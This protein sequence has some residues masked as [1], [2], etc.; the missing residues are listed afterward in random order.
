MIRKGRF[1]MWNGKEYALV[2]YQRQYYLQTE[3]VCEERNG[4]ERMSGKEHVLIRSVSLKELQEAYEIVPYTMLEGYRFA[5]EGINQSNGKVAL[6]T[7]NPFVKGKVD[8]QP[9]GSL[10]YI[11]ELPVDQVDF[12]EERFPLYG[13]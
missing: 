9:Y 6:V 13:M 1:A 2:S 4:F 10:E 12:L 7:N 8:V 11:I 5:V 3:E